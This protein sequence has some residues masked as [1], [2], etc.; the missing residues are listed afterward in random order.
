MKEPTPPQAVVF[1]GPNGSGKSTSASVLLPPG[2]RFINADLIAQELTG[3]SG[4]GADLRAG[5]LL[6]QR[7]EMLEEQRKDF[8]L[9][10]TLATAMLSRRITRLRE[11]GYEAHLVFFWLPSDDLAVQRV[12]A[13]VRAGGH[14]VPEDTIRR[15]FERGLALLFNTYIGLFDTWRI[16]DNSSL[17]DPQLIAA[18]GIGREIALPQAHTLERILEDVARFTHLDDASLREAFRKGR[19]VDEAVK[20]AVRRALE[21]HRR[22]QQA[23]A[24][25]QDGEVVIVPPEGIPIR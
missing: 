2:F 9:E 4:T 14:N 25:W 23:V 10:T 6:L 21:Q 18:G 19:P 5:R 12:A 24:A 11:N 15:R 16:Y 20:Q 22:L 3:H 7:I 8:A 17:S 13:R 1:A